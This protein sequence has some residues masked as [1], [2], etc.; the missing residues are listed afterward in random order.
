MRVLGA[1]Q[2]E[3]RRSR[4][5]CLLV[6]GWLALDAG[7]LTSSLAL[8]DQLA[9]KVTVITHHHWDHIKDL[10]TLAYNFFNAGRDLKVICQTETFS[11]IREIFFAS[12][13]WPDL[14]VLPPATPTLRHIPVVAGQE[15]EL[16]G[17]RVGFFPS[18]HKVPTLGLC[19]EHGGRRVVYTSD[20]S[21]GC[22]EHWLHY[23]PHLLITEVTLPDRLSESAVRAFH[24]TPSALEEE[25]RAK[26]LPRL[27]HLTVAAL[28]RNPF[29]G[30]ELV[31]ALQAVAAR[32]GCQILTPNEGDEISV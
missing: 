21:A 14:T 10:P 13:I 19:I 26:I 23:D 31:Q 8:A 5:T 32:T 24:L 12:G 25:L 20:T 15:V 11:K 3:D 28:H 16:E 9:I 4:F 2:A 30:D 1:H 6:D 22:T 27:P 18:C 29:Y 7:G 17:Y